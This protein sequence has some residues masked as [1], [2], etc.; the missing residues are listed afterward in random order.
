[1]KVIGSW[2]TGFTVEDL[3]RS[4]A[5]YR[6]LLGFEVI[7]QRVSSAE[8]LGKL[9]GY[10]GVEMHQAL[11]AMPGT[12][13][14]FELNDYRGIE[15][16][17][18]VNPANGNPG[19]AHLCVLVDDIQAFYERFIEAGVEVISEPVGPTE[20][21][22]VGNL[23]MYVVDPDGVRVELLQGVPAAHFDAGRTG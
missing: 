6:D 12:A 8:Y 4:L 20:G 1:M 23:V 7:W 15:R 11:L 14:T 2:H 21:P 22:N 16:S 13:H 10:P 17:P 18:V 3:D 19:T 5:F 9:V